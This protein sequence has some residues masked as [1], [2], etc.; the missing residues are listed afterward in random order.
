MLSTIWSM[1]VNFTQALVLNRAFIYAMGAAAG[2]T[3]TY[4][5]QETRKTI[6]LNKKK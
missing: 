2:A 3:A 4:A 1:Y 6:R 5:I